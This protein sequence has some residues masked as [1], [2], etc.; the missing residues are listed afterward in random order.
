MYFNT[1]VISNLVS[2]N[3][4]DW[5]LS[6]FVMSPSFFEHFLISGAVSCVLIKVYTV[7]TLFSVIQKKNHVYIHRLIGGGG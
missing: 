4:A 2:G 1:Q 7:S 3:F 5:L 6:P